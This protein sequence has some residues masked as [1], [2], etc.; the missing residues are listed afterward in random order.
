MRKLLFT[1][2]LLLTVCLHAQTTSHDTIP[3]DIVGGK[4]A[5]HNFVVHHIEATTPVDNGAKPGTYT[6][7]VSFLVDTTGN[8]SD[9][10]LEQDPGYGTGADV[11]HAFT[12]PPKWTP[13]T[14][15]GKPVIYR[16]KKEVVYQVEKF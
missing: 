6:V 12:H 15:D 9:V 2:F 10:R 7:V 4:D 3:G 11:M 8:I 1:C 16:H 13:A 5:W 14:V